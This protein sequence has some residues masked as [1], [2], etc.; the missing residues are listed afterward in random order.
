MLPPDTDIRRE[1]SGDVGAIRALT[2][3]A[4]ASAKHSDGTE[5]DIIDRLR[6]R[7]KLTCSLVA[8]HDGNIVGHV[9]FSPVCIAG[10][11]AAQSE[12]YGLGPVS[13]APALQGQ[14]IGKALIKQGLTVLKTHHNAGGC[15]V[16]GDPAYYQ[17]FGF[18]PSIT[19]TF[20]H[21][22]AEYFMT[23]SFDR[24]MPS[25]IVHY[26]AAFGI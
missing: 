12:W 21:A 7:G 18:T 5:Q 4:F 8:C 2:R 6:T 10:T 13:V 20:P 3:L 19:L 25:G 24:D 9:A 26:D 16:L 14:G 15:V 17:K 22:P 11:P 1:Q 23:Q